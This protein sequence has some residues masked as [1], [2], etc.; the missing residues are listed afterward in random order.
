MKIAMIIPTTSKN[1]DSWKK[2]KDTYLYSICVKS[3]VTHLSDSDKKHSYCFYIGYDDDDRLFSEQSTHDEFHYLSNIF[4]FISFKFIPFN[5]IPKGYVTK[6]WNV[7]FKKSYDDNYDYFYQCGDDITFKSK[8]W[9]TDSIN[10]LL[11]SNNIGLTG[12][13]NNNSRILT[14]SFVSRTHM[15][16]FGY[17]FPESIIN[18][19]CD[20]W[21]NIVYKPDLFFPLHQHYCSNDG[22]E[23]RYKINNDDNF[24][25]ERFN[26]KL[27]LLRNETES[28]AA[29][30]KEKIK[31]YM[32]QI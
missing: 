2:P 1:R 29:V 30:D 20:D 5:N 27:Q 15:E 26:E 13:I 9:V 8:N 16:I 21:Y 17:F 32:N 7:L 25:G 11:K 19:C 31:K 28:I 22:G 24:Y 6:M 10:T 4:P 23:P 14:Q 3:F 12:P 18:W